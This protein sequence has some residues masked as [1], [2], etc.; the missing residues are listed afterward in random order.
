MHQRVATTAWP[1]GTAPAR[2]GALGLL[3]ALAVLPL[4]C[5]TPAAAYAPA[6]GPG[7]APARPRSEAPC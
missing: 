2:H 4:L 3:A 7:S 1:V 5:G 6:P